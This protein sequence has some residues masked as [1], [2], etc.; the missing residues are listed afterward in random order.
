LEAGAG[1]VTQAFDDAAG[2][3]AEG[4]IGA[5]TGAAD[6]EQDA[7]NPHPRPFPR[8]DRGREERSLRGIRLGAHKRL[9]A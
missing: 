5:A 8:R 1:V 3:G 9:S 4:H 6:D 2:D 7:D